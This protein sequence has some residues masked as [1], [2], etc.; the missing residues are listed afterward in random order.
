[1]K[2]LDAVLNRIEKWIGMLSL[3][4]MTLLVL[5]QIVFRLSGIPVAWTEELARYMFVY[6][7]FFGASYAVRL[8][9]HLKVE[10]LGALVKER[11]SLVF[12]IITCVSSLV[13][14]II[15]ARIMLRI[16]TNMLSVRMLTPSLQLNLLWVYLAPSVFTVF[17]IIRC[18]QNI[19]EAVQEFRQ[20]PAK[21]VEQ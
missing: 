11:G 18:V 19:W 12:R 3:L 5:I 15:L 16:T 17:S 1:M 8:N 20:L 9:R 4:A 6:S 7:I 2:I 14:Y 13:F 21:G 10:V